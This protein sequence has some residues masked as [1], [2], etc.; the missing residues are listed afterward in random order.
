MWFLWHMESNTKLCCMIVFDIMAIIRLENDMLYAETPE[1]VAN[2]LDKYAEEI[3]KQM[4]DKVMDARVNTTG[5]A[6]VTLVAAAYQAAAT[7]RL[8]I[9]IKKAAE[10]ASEASR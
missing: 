7:E 4:D 10:E 1:T 6:Y 3:I 9:A 2:S 5:D 8:R